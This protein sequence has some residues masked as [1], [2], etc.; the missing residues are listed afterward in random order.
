MGNPTGF[1]EY[2]RQNLPREAV[3][4]RLKH[5]R[6]IEESLPDKVARNQA[7][8]CMDCGV[9]FCHGETG[10]P[11]D[12]YIPEWNDLVYRGLWKRALDI[13]HLTNNF[14]EFTGRLCP[15][16]CETACTLGINDDAVTIKYTE[17][18][19]IAR[20]FSEG[21]VKPQPPAEL[22]GKS[23]AIV[24]SGPAGLASAQQLARMGHTVTVYEKNDRIGGLM[25]Y[26]IPDFK[27][28]KSV[29]DR[30]LEQ[31]KTEGVR[32]KTSVHIGID[33]PIDDLINKNDAVILAGGS[34]TNR[35]LP[36]KGRDL[37]GIHFAM[38]FLPQQNK[39]NA[40]DK[41]ENQISA[42]NKKVVVIGGGDTGSDCVGTS[43]R[44][45]A[46]SVIQL[47][48]M[49]KPPT[50]RDPKTPWPYW[51][52]MYRKSSSHEEGVTQKYSVTT[53]EFIGDENGN[54]KKLICNEVKFE[55][56]KLEDIEGTEF[57]IEADLVLLAM[58]FTHPTQ[59]GMLS[60][61]KEKGLEFDERQNIKAHYGT[62]KKSFKTTIDKVFTCGD[63]RR[64]QSLIVWAI[65]EGRKCASSVHKHLMEID[66]KLEQTP[67]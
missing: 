4:S 39:V 48:I 16:P 12:N 41:I 61:L 10:C 13:L 58:G 14:P 2:K 11:V 32:F 23:V 63:M 56:G 45:G 19:I 1:L 54:L 37:K 65:A 53:K 28:E 3:E 27:M 18:K 38:E 47:E 62:K 8:R 26:G 50:E 66:D 21:L 57:E 6:E 55:N 52:N 67:L 5:Y 33:I 15:A 29:I 43:N 31:L 25:R 44:Q 42:K 9:P 34:E 36:I 40:G 51:A 22:S 60:Q 49:P 64:G 24:G 17:R 7:S 59:T 20:G 35:D 46:E 30:R